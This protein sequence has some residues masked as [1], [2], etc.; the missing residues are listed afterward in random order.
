MIRQKS[1]FCK[2]IQQKNSAASIQ[3]EFMKVY[4]P[5]KDICPNCGCR[6]KCVLFGTYE[7]NVLDY[8]HSQQKVICTRLT[9]TRVLCESCSTADHKVTHAILTDAIVPYSPYSL[10]FIL[11][12]L[13]CRICLG[14]K[15]ADICD[16]FEIHVVQIYRW[17]NLLKRNMREWLG[18]LEALEQKPEGFLRYLMNRENY[19]E[20]FG[21]PFLRRTTRSLLQLH[22][23]PANCRYP[24]FASP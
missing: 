5:F 21:D 4:D 1:L 9:I 6:G 17:L 12:V 8:D 16:R 24:K 14:W 2:L 18:V 10:L 13:Y 19:S 23:N 3:K 20:E 22:A 15:L 7:R 11:H